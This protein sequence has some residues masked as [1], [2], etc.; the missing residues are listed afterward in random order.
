M[1]ADVRVISSE[2]AARMVAMDN[3]TEKAKEIIKE[4]KLEFNKARQAAITT[5][6]LE[7]VGGAEAL[8]D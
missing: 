1:A 3:A 8:A 6:M 4:L 2:E 5:E 7:I